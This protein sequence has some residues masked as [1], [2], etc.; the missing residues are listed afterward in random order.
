MITITRVSCL[1]TRDTTLHLNASDSRIAT[2]QTTDGTN[3]TNFAPPFESTAR[4]ITGLHHHTTASHNNVKPMVSTGQPK[5]TKPAP[6]FHHGMD[7]HRSDNDIDH[8][9]NRPRAKHTRSS[10][11]RYEMAS[12]NGYRDGPNAESGQSSS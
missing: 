1:R 7:G 3:E 4:H 9:D 10:N 2:R 6:A 8:P 12:D 11:S 5:T